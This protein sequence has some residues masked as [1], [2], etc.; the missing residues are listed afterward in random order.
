[1]KITAFYSRRIIVP[2]EEPYKNITYE[3]GIEFSEIECFGDPEEESKNL[4]NN[5]EQIIN[6]HQREHIKEQ[7][8][9]TKLIIDKVL[10][11][12]DKLRLKRK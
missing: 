7:T 1:M 3:H 6:E 10:S 4:L 5:L 2:I 11:K 8:G 12:G 9:V